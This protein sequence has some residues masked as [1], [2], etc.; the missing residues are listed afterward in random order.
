MTLG[1]GRLLFPNLVLYT[2]TSEHYLAELFGGTLR[3]Q[4]LT[5]RNH[6]EES[7]IRYLYQ[8]EDDSENPLF[9]I[10]A[11]NFVLSNLALSREV[12]IEKVKERFGFNPIDIHPTRIVMK[13]GGGSVISFGPNFKSCYLNN[14]LII[15]SYERF[16]RMKDVLHLSIASKTLARKDLINDLNGQCIWPVNNSDNTYGMHY[17]PNDLIESYKLSGQFA[18]LF[19]VP[20][21]REPNIGKFLHNNSA[22]IMKA[23]DYG[24]LLYEK[25]FKWMQGNPDSS[26]LEIQPDFMLK[27]NGANY[28]DICDIKKPLQN[29][30]NITTGGHARRKF[31]EEVNDGIAQL[32]N[33]EQYFSFS[34]NVK[35]AKEK[36]KVEVNSPK[37][38]LIIG[39]YEN[40]NI[41][42][43]KEA[44]RQLKNNFTI[45][46]YDSLNAAY[47]AGIRKFITKT[48]RQS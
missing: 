5:E 38:I 41:E 6:R 20:G 3:F 42:E 16:Y 34:V 33:Y 12:D 28:W 39:S 22:L 23:L 35:Y 30:A 18:N 4:G 31:I 46:D 1:E 25:P 19:L 13:K 37:L 17:V 15:N 21:I 9:I 32:A 26:E 48:S 7:T 24:D 27:P 29:K 11:A 43:I 40:S 2:E 47:L 44:S 14:C 36:Y 45:M 8:F 10:D